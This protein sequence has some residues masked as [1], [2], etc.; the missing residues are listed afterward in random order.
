MVLED[1]SMPPDCAV[2]REVLNRVGDRW[3]VFVVWLLRDGPKRFSELKRANI[4]IS[5]RMLTLTLRGLER[6][7]FVIRT[8]SPTAPRRVDYALSPLGR[9]LFASVLELAQF[10]DTNRDEIL[11]ARN[12]FDSREQPRPSEVRSLALPHEEI[13]KAG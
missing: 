10:A 7:G 8:V 3:S 1:V 4:G 12:R 2:I 5:Q 9:T 11:S 13:D 6:D